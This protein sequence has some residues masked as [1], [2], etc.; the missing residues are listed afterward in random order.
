MFATLAKCLAESVQHL[1][2]N[3]GLNVNKC[4]KTSQSQSFRVLVLLLF[5]RVQ[6]PA[7]TA[8]LRKGR[9][10]QVKLQAAVINV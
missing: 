3:S 6:F 9:L 4:V 7:A 1:W 2:G 8:L 10:L 5:K